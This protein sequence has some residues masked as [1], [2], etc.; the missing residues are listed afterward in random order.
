MAKQKREDAEA[1]VWN[2]ISA[3]EQILE[4][5]PTDRASLEALSHAYQQIG[6]HTKAKEYLIRLGNQLLDEQDL[7]AMLELAEKLSAYAAEDAQAAELLKRIQGVTSGSAAP[8]PAASQDVPE[9]QPARAPA[10]KVR[11]AFNMA[12]ELALAWNLL[13]AHEINQEE[14]ASLVQDLTE[15]SAN[16]ASTTVSVFHVL[17][18]RTFKNLDRILAYTSREFSVPYISLASFDVPAAVADVLPLEFIIRRGALAFGFIGQEL[19]VVLMNPCEKQLR[20]DT[21]QLSGRRC[22]FFLTLPSEFDVAVQ[23]IAGV[24]AEREAEEAKAKAEA[25]AAR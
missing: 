18:A 1:E 21:E 17:E 12:E 9:P 16:D 20:Q 5:M 4:A 25:A 2:A 10:V 8:V 15:M 22:H 23:K 11:M 6:D 13:E 14:Y 24:L 7:Q 19:M 3:F